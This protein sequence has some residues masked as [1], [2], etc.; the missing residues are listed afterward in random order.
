MRSLKFKE[1]KTILTDSIPLNNYG[2]LWN[3]SFIL[4]SKMYGSLGK[5]F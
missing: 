3:M 4:F 5:N 1:F 2:K